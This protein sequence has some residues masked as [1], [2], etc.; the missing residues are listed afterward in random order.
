MKIH[1]PFRRQ[2]YKCLVVRIIGFSLGLEVRPKSTQSGNG[3]AE[4]SIECFSQ[5]FCAVF[6]QAPR[7]T[8]RQ[9]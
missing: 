6:Q 7:F 4:I 3:K 1:D 9:Y 5:D 2:H 8:L